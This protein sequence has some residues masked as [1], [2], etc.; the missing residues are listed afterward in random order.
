MIENLT[1]WLL[2]IPAIVI[3]T[4]FAAL[5]VLAVVIVWP[6]F[7]SAFSTEHV[8]ELMRRKRMDDRKRR[9]NADQ[10]QRLPQRLARS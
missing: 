7:W 10:T 2:Y 5:V 9:T 8:E 4:L 1:K 3:C 6:G